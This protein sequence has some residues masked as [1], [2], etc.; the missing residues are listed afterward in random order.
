[1]RFIGFIMNHHKTLQAAI[2]FISNKHN[3]S[4]ESGLDACISSRITTVI[5]VRNDHR[6]VYEDFKEPDEA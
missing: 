1:M 3:P 4:A 6:V 5:H 2:G